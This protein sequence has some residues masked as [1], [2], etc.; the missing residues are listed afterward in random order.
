M[1]LVS[2]LV[3]GGVG[4]DS[5]ARY[6][7]ISNETDETVAAHLRGDDRATA[8]QRVA[9]QTVGSLWSSYTT[10]RPPAIF[11]LFDR[12]CREIGSITVEPG[13][14]GAVVTSGPTVEIVRDPFPGDSLN[15][16][17]YDGFPTCEAVF[18]E[19]PGSSP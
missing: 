13:D 14:Q 1:S 19:D 3:L 12:G 6:L 2:I 15:L 18:R 4:C 11:R 9:P 8:W 5:G 17:E 10:P 16:L 7:W